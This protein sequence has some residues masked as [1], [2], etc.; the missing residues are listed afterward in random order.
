MFDDL[1]SLHSAWHGCVGLDAEALCA[2][3]SSRAAPL[4]APVAKR[5][6]ERAAPLRAVAPASIPRT[7][8]IGPVE[9]NMR[10]LRALVAVAQC[11][12]VHRAADRLHVTQSAVTRAVRALEDELGLV[13]FDR[14]PRGM[15]T[16]AC[17]QILVERACRALAY[18]EAADLELARENCGGGGSGGP[19]RSSRG[20]AGKVAQ[21]HLQTVSAI[22]DH[23]TETASAQ[24]LGISQPAVTQGLRD[25]EE[26]VNAPLF[27]RTP[28]GMVPTRSGD[29][30]IRC[31]K[32]AL[33]E[34][35]AAG[36]D[37]AAHL[38]QVRGRLAVGALPLSGT[39]IAPLVVSRVARS[40]PDLRLRVTEAP[41]DSLL[42]S[43]RCGDIDLIVGALHAHPPADVAQHRLFDDELS[44]VVRHGH[45][46]AQRG[47][48]SLD[49]LA[50]AEWVVPFRRTS[51]RNT[52]ENAMLAAGL[53]LPDDAIE[54][55]TVVTVRG[56]LMESDRLSVLSRRQIYYEEREGLLTV[57]PIRLQGTTLPI[58]YLVRADARSTMA[59]EAVLQH[60]HEIS[61]AP[62]RDS[63]ASLGAALCAA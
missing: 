31:A 34:I 29:I 54:A 45:P 39:Q 5:P 11:R 36:D 9:A 48:L 61:P 17:G 30:M 10:R 3:A 26:M 15:S 51:S 27:M 46:L 58:G 16:T 43:L 28:K 57:L 52:V 13:L 8:E 19:D 41:Y 55:N 47:A 12:S 37:L 2:S 62:P 59:L 63:T 40:Y 21:R 14:S 60:L 6:G 53:Q 56:L 32:L 1:R 25:L 18:L 38:G 7:A 23:L 35:A 24:Q 22:A 4:H 49:D 44:V 42:K 33:N 50:G 20:L